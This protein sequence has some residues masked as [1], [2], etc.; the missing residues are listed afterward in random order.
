MPPVG[1]VEVC[2]QVINIPTINP[3]FLEIKTIQSN[4]PHPIIYKLSLKNHSYS[5]AAVLVILTMV[6]NELHIV[7]THRT[8]LVN[9]HKDQVSF[10]GGAMDVNDVSLLQTGM[11]ET[12][13]EIGI[14]IKS[15]DVIARLNHILTPFNFRITPYICWKEKIEYYTPNPHEVARVFT[16]PLSWFLIPEHKKVKLIKSKD[17]KKRRAIFYL[18]YDREEVWGI[19]AT[20]IHQLTNLL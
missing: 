13:E 2:L 20:I 15:E 5:L 18:P 1:I 17:G 16:I 9:T 12:C 7:F 6:E 19:T 4:N 14:E 11:R 3:D 10:P 8:G